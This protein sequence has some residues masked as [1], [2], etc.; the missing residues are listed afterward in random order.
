MC[1]VGWLGH[2]G[3]VLGTKLFANRP[4]P[5]PDRACQ[6]TFHSLANQVRMWTSS[7]N[8][9]VGEGQS[10]ALEKPEELLSQRQRTGSDPW[11]TLWNTPVSASSPVLVLTSIGYFSDIKEDEN[12]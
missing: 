7:Q 3:A 1:V 12:F 11:V 2:P 9:E 8:L 4:M 6:P 10:H 5:I